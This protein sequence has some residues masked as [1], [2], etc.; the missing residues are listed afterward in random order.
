MRFA[1]DYQA[2]TELTMKESYAIPDPRTIIDKLKGSNVYSFLDVALAYWYLKVREQDIEKTAFS[3][4]KG[5]YQ[6]VVRVFGL[7]SS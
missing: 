1:I 4:P 6:M 7:C 2:L 5:H 3:I